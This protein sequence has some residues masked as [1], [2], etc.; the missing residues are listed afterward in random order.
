MR[1]TAFQSSDVGVGGTR[2]VEVAI[3]G[4][5][6]TGIGMA[7]RLKQAG[8]HDFEILER[9]EDVGGTWRQNSYPGCAVDVQSHL[10]SYSFAPNPDWTHVYSPAPEIRAYARRCAEDFGVLE[11]VRCG[12]AVL[13][14]AWHADRQR[15]HITTSTGVVEARFLVSAMGLLSAPAR[16]DTPASTPSRARA[17]TQPR[18]ITIMI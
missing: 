18:G 2:C 7:I 16:P 9:A 8:I 12:Q 17:F 10:Y 3:V 5:G 13:G 4:G 14:A 11:H 1:T 6:L 15:W